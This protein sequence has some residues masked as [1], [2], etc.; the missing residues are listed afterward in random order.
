MLSLPALVESVH[1]DNKPR[2]RV[3]ATLGRVE[4][5]QADGSI[6][7]LVSSLSKFSPNALALIAGKSSPETQALT[8]GPVLIFE[9]LWQRL[10]LESILKELLGERHFG[11]AVERAV[12]LSVLHRVCCGGSDRQAHQWKEDYEIAGVS[13]LSLHHSYRAMAWLGQAEPRTDLTAAGATRAP[14]DVAGTKKS[15]T[16]AAPSKSCRGPTPIYRWH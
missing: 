14:A 16:A 4:Q 3:L 11:F 8:I 10:K 13:K 12:F 7:A 15:A 2:Q 1:T 5:L 9:R 6:D